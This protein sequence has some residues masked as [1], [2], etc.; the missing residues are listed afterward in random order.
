MERNGP[1]MKKKQVLSALIAGTLAAMV[2]QDV[3]KTVK[4]RRIT[5]RT[6]APILS[7]IWSAM[8]GM[9]WATLSVTSGKA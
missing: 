7:A 6:T 3:V 8:P 2:L 1:D 9:A 5:I 4:F